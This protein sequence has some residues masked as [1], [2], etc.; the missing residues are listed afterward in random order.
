MVDLSKVVGDPSGVK[1]SFGTLSVCL[2]QSKLRKTTDLCE[3]TK[4]YDWN[5]DGTMLAVTENIV[6]GRQSSSCMNLHLNPC[7][8]AHVL[9]SDIALVGSRA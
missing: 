5:S 4:D 2:S 6:L 8:D 1:P 7:C 9:G 3:G